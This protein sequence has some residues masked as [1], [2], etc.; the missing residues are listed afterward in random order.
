MPQDP[1]K[2][3]RGIGLNADPNSALGG[4]KSWFF[5]IGINKYA[6][7]TLLNNAVKDLIALLQ[8]QYDLSS[9]YTLTLYDGQA[10]R[11]NI[12]S[13]LDQLERKVGP[14]DKLVI[15]Y[16][17][18]GHLN[19]YNGKGYWISTDAERDNSAAYIRNS[20]IREYV[21]TLKAL[22]PLL[23]SDACFSGSLFVR[24]GDRSTAA[25][26]DLASLPSRW[27]F[28]SGR[29]DE[30]VYD[31]EP[32]G[33]S[34]FAGS[35]I[36]TLRRNQ[37]KAF[38]VAKLVDRVVEQTR[39]NYRQLPEGNPLYGVGHMGGQYIFR[40]RADEA[41]DWA[42][43]KAAATLPAYRQY[44]ENHPDGRHA[45]EARE[46]IAFLEEEVA[47]QKAKAAHTLPMIWLTPEDAIAVLPWI[48]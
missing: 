44:L 38:N 11:K 16:S 3:Q 27:A 48:L 20:T 39:S 32:G 9:E 30:Q 12:I 5:G 25:L 42:A 19:T 2:T 21:E 7:F 13:T 6:E 24:G 10:T 47:W 17:G 41:D 35:I 46:A 40:R 31:G 34:P 45:V 4:G 22:H 14:A 26:Q 43:A 29:H 37:H 23:I 1:D 18:H 15:Y 33:N 8:E 28:C 36:D